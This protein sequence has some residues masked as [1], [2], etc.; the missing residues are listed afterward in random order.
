M[1]VAVYIR[2]LTEDQAREGYSHS[3]VYAKLNMGTGSLKV[4]RKYLEAFAQ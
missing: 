3:F 1:K 2:A 4:K